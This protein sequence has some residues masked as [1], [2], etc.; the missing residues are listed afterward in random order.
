MSGVR[1]KIDFFYKII[2]KR[3]KLTKVICLKKKKKSETKRMPSNPIQWLKVKLV[4]Q[5]S[6]SPT[7]T[8]NNQNSTLLSRGSFLSKLARCDRCCLTEASGVFVE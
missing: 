8:L 3:L 6:L 7:S 5:I 2:N 1:V 4:S